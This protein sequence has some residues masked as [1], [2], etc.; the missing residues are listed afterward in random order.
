MKKC[1]VVEQNPLRFPEFNYLIISRNNFGNLTQSAKLHVITNSQSF[2]YSIFALEN[3]DKL[4]T[5]FSKRFKK[6]P[7]FVANRLNVTLRQGLI[8]TAQNPCETS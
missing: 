5:I 4:S 8:Y 1:P 7:S 2:S 6:R 3:L